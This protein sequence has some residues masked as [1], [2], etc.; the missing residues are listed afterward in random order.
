MNITIARLRSNVKYNGPL[1]TVLD[2]FFENY[3]KWMKDNPQH[4]YKTY[5]VS[6]DN[7][8]PKR[9]PETI[10][11]ADVIIIPSDSE[12]RYHGK[13]PQINPK[14]LARS[15][16]H[17]DDIRTY[18]KNKHVIV[19]QS[20]R[21]DTEALYR[22]ETLKN[23]ELKPFNTI[24]E[25]DFSANIHGMKYH[26]MQT[27]KSPLFDNVINKT[28]DF[29]YWG[30]M[31]DAVRG[32]LIRQISRSDLST[33][34]VGGFPSGVVRHSK[35][36]KD[37]HILYPMLEPC[38]STLCFNW[39]D[40]TASTAR[41]VEALAMD[42]VPFVW[43]EYDK[44][45]TYNID[46][47]QRVSSFEEFYEKVLQLRDNKFFEFKLKSYKNNFKQILLSEDEYF[48]E[49]SDKMNEYIKENIK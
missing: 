21:A 49:F 9:T 26:F 30:K 24:D 2:S 11:W 22:N 43:K 23:I 39:L 36:I 28:S 4:E 5:N 6:F 32:K 33:I 44:N 40:P 47:W 31:K 35:W 19:W 29:A 13:V 42:I 37:W 3:V 18:F 14:D 17:M 20:D 7:T 48:K 45:S 34:L 16:K 25:V 41:Y 8:R 12:F 46:D 27:L 15:E 1:K 10:E 38:R